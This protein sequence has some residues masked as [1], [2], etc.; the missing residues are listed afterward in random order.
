MTNFPPAEEQAPNN[1]QQHDQPTRDLDVDGER[2]VL[3]FLTVPTVPSV[4]AA[5]ATGLNPWVT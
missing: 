3:F 1:N 2:A 5:Q 4:P